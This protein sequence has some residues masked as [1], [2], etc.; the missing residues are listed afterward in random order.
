MSRTKVAIIGSGNIGTD[1][2]IKIM[3]LSEHLEMARHGRHRPRLRRPGPRPAA[4]RRRPPPTASTAWSRWPTSTTSRSSST[5]PRPGPTSPTPRRSRRTASGSSTSRRRRSAPTSCPPVNLDAAPRRAERQHGHLRRPGHHPDRRRGRTAVTPVHYARDRR[6]DRLEVGRARAPAP[7]STSSPRPPRHAIE[8][9]GGAAQRQGDH[10]AQPGRAAA[11]HARHRALPDD[12]LDDADRTRGHAPRS[13][14]MVAESPPTSPATGSSSRS[15]SRPRPRRTDAHPAS[16]PGAR[17]AH[18]VS[19]FL[20]VEG[21]AHYLPAYAG[22]LDIM[23]SAALRVAEQ[24]AAA[25]ERSDAWR[26]PHD[27]PTGG[28]HPGRHPARRHA[29]HPPPV[30]ASTR[31]PPSPRPSTPPASTPSR[32]PT[33]TASPARSLTYGSGSHTDWEW[34]ERRRRGRRAAP[35]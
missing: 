31:S 24:L 28:L 33:A 21:A 14:Q 19:V 30:H 32:S 16:R 25:R 35:G 18:Q 6:L 2:M 12:R 1:L 7:T 3:R 13:T 11:D 22:N 29:R 15:S 5:P 8:T 17:R 9:V 20:E 26:P 23:T 34:I 27:T 4:G 10:R